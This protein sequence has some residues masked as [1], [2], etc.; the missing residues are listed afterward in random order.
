MVDVN[1]IIDGE[2]W[3]TVKDASDLLGFSERH[4]WNF[5]KKHAIETKKELNKS[6][7]VTYIRRKD[8][9]KY[10][11]ED[12]KRKKL[13]RLKDKA[14][15]EMSERDEKSYFEMSES[16]DKALSE[17][18]VALP[19][20]FQKQEQLVKKA[21]K[22]RIIAV[23]LT[24]FMVTLSA[25]F[26]LLLKDRDKA[27]SEREKALSESQEALS[28]MRNRAFT[29][30]EREKEALLQKAETEKELI[31]KEIDIMER[32]SLIEGLKKELNKLIG[33]KQL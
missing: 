27:L 10:A 13:G 2:N 18:R 17:R 5:I 11:K 6:R 28:E 30:S 12:D 31:K 8:I 21:V 33:S 22:W 15:S 1:N 16:Q 19:A 14:L 26:Y 3:I 20:L 9:E 7:K 29:L 4:A 23:W 32:D 25:G 24:L